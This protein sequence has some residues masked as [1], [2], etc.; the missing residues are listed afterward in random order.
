VTATSLDDTTDF[1]IVS[2]FNGTLVPGETA[3]VSVRASPTADGSAS[4]DLVVTRAGSSSDLTV[5]LTATGISPTLTIA[6][7]ISGEF[8]EVSTSSS[9]VQ[10]LSI[11]NDGDATLVLSNIT[12][13][14]DAYQ[15]LGSQSTVTVSP[16]ETRNIR[17][18]FGPTAPGE[19]FD[20]T[21]S[22]ET[23]DGDQATITRDLSGTG[24]TAETSISE[25]SVDF[26]TIDVESSGLTELELTNDGE[27]PLN[28]T[29]VTISG[30]DSSAFDVRDFDSTRLAPNGEPGD[31]EAF[32]VSVSPTVAQSLTAQLTIGTGQGASDV[33]VALGATGTEPELEV[34]SQQITF[35]RTRLGTTSTETLDIQNAG[36][37]PLDVRDILVSGVDSSQFSISADSAVIPAESSRTV[38]VRF[39]PNINETAATQGTQ[40]QATLTLRSNDTDQTA[41]NVNI[42]GQSKTPQLDLPSV[43]R[44]GSLR[45]GEETTRTLEVSNDPTATADITIVDTQLVGTNAGEFDS[46]AVTPSSTLEPGDTSS[47]DVS[48]EPESGGVKSASLLVATNDPEQPIE[49]VSLSNSRTVVIVRYGSVT[50]DYIGV[51]STD[52]KP[53]ASSGPNTGV[54]GIDP[55]LNAVVND[56]NMTFSERAETG[57]PELGDDTPAEP[58]RYLNVDTDN[59]APSQ[60]NQTTVEFRV[61]KAAIS[62]L[63]SVEDG[64]TLYQYDGSEYTALETTRLPGDDTPSTYAYTATIDSFGDLAIGAGQ[65]DLSLTSAS[66]VDSS[67]PDTL[68]DGD[69]TDI[70][71][72]AD[73]ENAGSIAGSDTVRVTDSSGATLTTESANVDVSATETVSLTV[74]ITGPGTRTLTV[75]AVGDS[76]DVTVDIDAPSGGG[77]PPSFGDDDDDDDRA[78]DDDDDGADDDTDDSAGAD[79]ESPAPPA[80]LEGVDVTA[81]EVVVPQNISANQRVA[82]FETVANV[83]RITFNTTD[84]IDEVQVSD[85]DPANGTVETLGST[86]AVQDITVSAN[87]SNTSATIEFTI[88]RDRLDE[89][90]ATPEELRTFRTVDGEFEPLNTT[91]EEANET[92]A[93]TA[94]TPGFSVF[95]VSAVSEPE[96]VIDI[97]P[98]TIQP[99][100]TVELSANGS[101]NKHGEITSY[102]WSAGGDTLTGET[103]QTTFDE[104]GEYTVELT[105][106]NDA[107]E[108]NTTTANLVVEAVDDGTDDDSGD[109]DGAT[110]DDTA[111]DG[112]T[113]DDTAGDEATGDDT[114]GDGATDDDGQTDD[115]I[116]GFGV[117]VA[118]IALIAA[119]G[120]AASRRS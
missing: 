61:S 32:N 88:P 92:V 41:V 33:N 116:P 75:E 40:Q 5:D 64:I 67:L 21:L 120:I 1:K 58:V 11:Q 44:F 97:A 26:G 65:P 98:D 35:D 13:S 69:S 111:G 103:A 53:K 43:S 7:D 20:G 51:A 55:T 56:F 14:T 73:I 59:L 8:G 91:V 49:S 39:T 47:I 87:S 109:D 79:D 93:V 57:G 110:G 77:G 46:G 52:P 4:T 42:V 89:V 36:N 30:A 62:N 107:G 83:D 15:I 48:V 112:A 94:E 29:Q 71:V 6:D 95:T 80:S 18:A 31:A 100:D 63:D 3:P 9:A 38:E 23:N 84:R 113:G 119:A 24:A 2:G 102:N 105:V 74:P 106:T 115:G 70:T 85:I 25:S 76:Q 78:D 72:E 19:S 68:A 17:V 81:T 104:A 60:H 118:L 50:F 90:E 108:S 66:V 101:E 12:A 10:T 86:L 96:A 37:S 54:I 114:A 117:I 82:E 22:I 99:G 16:D 45:V 27:S 34:P 28:V